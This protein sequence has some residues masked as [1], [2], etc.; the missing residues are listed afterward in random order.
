MLARRVGANLRGA[1]PAH[2]ASAVVTSRS[3]TAYAAAQS[4]K[5]PALADVKPDGAAEFNARQ[6]EYREGLIAAQRKKE[7]KESK[8]FPSD[9]LCAW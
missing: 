5:T 4:H 9:N 1:L 2:Q 8:S 7:Q 6:K 3:F